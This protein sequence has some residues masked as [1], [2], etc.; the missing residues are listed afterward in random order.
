MIKQYIRCIAYAAM[1]LFAIKML[2]YLVGVTSMAETIDH[3]KLSGFSVWISLIDDL[4]SVWQNQENMLVILFRKLA[5]DSFNDR[6]LE[7]ILVLY[8]LVKLFKLPLAFAINC[9]L[10]WLLKFGLTHALIWIA[11]KENE[12]KGIYLSF[13]EIDNI[14]YSMNSIKQLV[15]TALRMLASYVIHECIRYDSIVQLLMK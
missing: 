8:A 13:E 6:I 14:E 12:M 1:K 7:Q 11:I 3:E 5:I 4:Y 9:T 15:T 10:I 2:S